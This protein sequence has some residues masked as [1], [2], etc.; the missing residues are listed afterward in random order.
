M[1][2]G[3]DKVHL[4]LRRGR[5]ALALLGLALALFGTGSM[6]PPHEDDEVLVWVNHQPVTAEQL[7]FAEERLTGGSSDKLSATQ[8][9]SIINLLIDQELLLQR[10]GGADRWARTA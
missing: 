7:A 2:A 4:I 5:L 10:A 8:R 9:R 1:R 3:N 6:L